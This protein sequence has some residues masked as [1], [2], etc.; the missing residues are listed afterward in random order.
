MD[1][2]SAPSPARRSPALIK[3]SHLTRCPL[4]RRSRP[5]W[6]SARKRFSPPHQLF[7]AWDHIPGMTRLQHHLFSSVGLSGAG[8][9]LRLRTTAFSRAWSDAACGSREISKISLLFRSKCRRYLPVLYLLRTSSTVQTSAIQRCP[10]VVTLS[11]PT[12]AE[13]KGRKKPNSDIT[14]PWKAPRS[15]D[16]WCGAG[17]LTKDENNSGVLHAFGFIPPCYFP[18]HRALF[19]QK[20]HFVD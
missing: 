16:T 14:E 4:R 7:S 6:S 11:Q 1:P 19:G 8:A 5:I 17:C 13:R 15:S 2:L 12:P 3:H 18:F 20:S 10:Y 9:K